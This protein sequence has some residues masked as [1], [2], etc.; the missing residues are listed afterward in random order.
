MFRFYTD[1]GPIPRNCSP[2]LLLKVFFRIHAILTY[3]SNISLTSIPDMTLDFMI[4]LWL[5]V[6]I[7]TFT[8]FDDCQK[9]TQS[10]NF[11]VFKNILHQYLT[12]HFIV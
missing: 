11:F 3:K 6:F 2:K 7:V 1:C 9:R 5:G 10:Q 8:S 4:S 12:Y